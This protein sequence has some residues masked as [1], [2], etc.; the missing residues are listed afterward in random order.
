MGKFYGT[1][2]LEFYT[3]C[4][5]LYF[6]FLFFELVVALPR[7]HGL[8]ARRR[9]APAQT[10]SQSQSQTQTEMEIASGRGTKLLAV[11]TKFIL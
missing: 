6:I 1:A 5:H 3:I 10:E 2:I 4:I 8:P 11:H 9:L 7:L